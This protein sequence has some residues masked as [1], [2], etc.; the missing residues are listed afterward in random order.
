MHFLKAWDLERGYHNIGP[1]V[2]TVL[3]GEHYIHPAA[4]LTNFLIGDTPNQRFGWMDKDG[5]FFPI[6]AM[7]H[8]FYDTHTIRTN[9]ENS[10][11]AYSTLGLGENWQSLVWERTGNHF[12]AKR[13]PQCSFFMIDA[14]DGNGTL[15]ARGVC[16][17][18]GPNVVGLRITESGVQ[19]ISDWL[20]SEGLKYDFP[21]ATI[22]L[23]VS[24]NG[25]TVYGSV[26][27]AA[28]CGCG[29]PSGPLPFVPPG[30]GPPGTKAGFN[31]VDN[32]IAHVP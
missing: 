24:D 23:Q 6:Q 22:V 20:K 15:F 19:T 21:P 10:V 1:N 14:I 29:K 18:L 27:K 5:Q 17:A 9:N 12:N 4:D 30:D 11:V 26:N 31:P 3:N 16:P 28:G 32:F 7:P 25:K 8:W 13:L 2:G